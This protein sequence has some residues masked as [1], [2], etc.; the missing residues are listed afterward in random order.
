MLLEEEEAASRLGFEGHHW[1]EGKRSIGMALCRRRESRFYDKERS[2]M[3]SLG[4]PRLDEKN[5][6]VL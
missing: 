5:L 4:S 3:N 2:C 6:M 1:R